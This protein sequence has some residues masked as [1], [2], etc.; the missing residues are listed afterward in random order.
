MF[1]NNETTSHYSMSLL[2]YKNDT[3]GN[4]GYNSSKNFNIKAH[5]KT[6]D[7]NSLIVVNKSSKNISYKNSF[8]SSNNQNKIMKSNSSKQK[9]WFLFLNFKLDSLKL[10]FL[11]L[12][13]WYKRF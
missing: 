6:K 11:F 13:I 4:N 3:I 7:R 8:Q 1:E 12:S 5:D 10:M 9:S 2:K